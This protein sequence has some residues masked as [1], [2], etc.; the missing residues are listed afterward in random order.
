MELPLASRAGLVIERRFI[1]C[2]DGAV[3]LSQHLRGDGDR[4]MVTH[5]AGLVSHVEVRSGHLFFETTAGAW[6]AP[7]RFTLV[8]PPRSV[9]RLRLANAHLFTAGV[10]G[11][12]DFGRRSPVVLAEHAPLPPWGPWVARALRAAPQAELDPDAGVPRWLAQGRAWLHECVSGPRPVTDVARRLTLSPETF[13]RRF[14]ATWGIGPKEYCHRARLFQAMLG[15]LTGAA[16]VE[17]ALE[18][19]FQDLTRFYVQFRR[20]LSTTPSGYQVRKRKDEG[21]GT[22]AT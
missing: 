15:L 10:A 21:P 3:A 19:G 2:I 4:V 20:L 1:G 14:R 12:L 5:R 17:A 8:M 13:T 9:V 11:A 7:S 18:S 6:Q 16:I 22:V